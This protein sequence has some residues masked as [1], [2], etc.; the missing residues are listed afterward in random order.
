MEEVW[1]ST[2]LLATDVEV[3]QFTEAAQGLFELSTVN[4]IAHVLDISKDGLLLAGT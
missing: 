1:N 2:N 4:L 3:L